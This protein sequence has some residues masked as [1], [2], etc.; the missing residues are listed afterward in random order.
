MSDEFHPAILGAE[1]TD[2]ETGALQS[3]GDFV[4]YGVPSVL[5]SGA[6]GIYNTVLDGL[7]KEQ[8]DIQETIA[9]YDVN[10]GDYYAER[11]DAIDVVGGIAGSFVPGLLGVKILQAARAGKALGSVGRAMNLTASNKDQYLRAAIQEIGASGGVINKLGNP[12]YLKY[13]VFETVD[14]ALISTAFEAAVLV[15]MHDAPMFDKYSA[16]DFATNMAIGIGAGGV[17]GGAVSS[18]MCKHALVRLMLSF[19][20]ISL[21]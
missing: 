21:G 7:G 17:I 5:T 16:G 18:L 12:N 4:R 15:G 6:L 2:R 10:A 20:V 8:V 1:V 11:K 14:Q 3:I 9:K 13:M 19:K